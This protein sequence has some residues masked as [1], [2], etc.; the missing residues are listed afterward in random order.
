[1]SA[2]ERKRCLAT[3]EWKTLTTLVMEAA[4]LLPASPKTSRCFAQISTTSRGAPILGVVRLRRLAWPCADSAEGRDGTPSTEESLIRHERPGSKSIKANARL[5]RNHYR[6][7]SPSTWF[8]SAG[9]SL[10]DRVCERHVESWTRRSHGLPR[11]P[12]NGQAEEGGERY[13]LRQPRRKGR[14]VCR[15]PG[16]AGFA[17]APRPLRG[18]RIP[19]VNGERRHKK[20]APPPPKGAT[21]HASP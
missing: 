14:A 7:D 17:L 2:D 15:A 12:R 21:N 16:R 6:S 19:K 8:R 18:R 5:R 13:R 10:H 20:P 1:M 11:R 3:L 4:S 9:Q